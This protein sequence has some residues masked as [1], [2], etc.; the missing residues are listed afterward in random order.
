M[1]SVS[2]Q[3][4]VWTI[5]SVSLLIDFNGVDSFQA[6]CH[7]TGFFDRTRVG[8]QGANRDFEFRKPERT[9]APLHILR[10]RVNNDENNKQVLLENT[11]TGLL[12]SVGLYPAGKNDV[13][14]RV[15][16]ENANSSLRIEAWGGDN[17]ETDD[18]N[19]EKLL[20]LWLPGLDGTS[21]TGRGRNLSRWITILTVECLPQLHRNLPT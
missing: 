13:K 1:F 5:S 12:Q 20:F 3:T 14:N 6:P 10:S 8:I 7:G 9:R 2:L 4:Y 17:S 16:F 11:M 18:Q 19:N 15:V 21:K